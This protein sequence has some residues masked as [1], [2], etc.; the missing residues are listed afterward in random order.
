MAVA[1]RRARKSVKRT[2]KPSS[3]CSKRFPCAVMVG[4]KFLDAEVKTYAKYGKPEF[5]ITELPAGAEII[6]MTRKF[7]RKSKAAPKRM[8]KVALKKAQRTADKMMTPAEKRALRRAL[9]GVKS[10]RRGRKSNSD[11]MGRL[12]DGQR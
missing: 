8:S 4:G 3:K 9:S 10:K 6:P 7:S 11:G 12:G 5:V 1:R 2:R